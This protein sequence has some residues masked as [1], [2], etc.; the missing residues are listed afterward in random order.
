MLNPQNLSRAGKGQPK[1]NHDRLQVTLPKPILLRLRDESETTGLK[2]NAIIEQAL[3]A[4]WE[5]KR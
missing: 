4:Y 1:K 2:M 5:Q 3:K